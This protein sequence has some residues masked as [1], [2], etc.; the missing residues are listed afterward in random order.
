[1]CLGKR[2]TN[3]QTSNHSLETR[4]VFVRAPKLYTALFCR[5]LLVIKN[6]VCPRC[7]RSVEQLLKGNQLHAAYVRLGEVELSEP[8][9]SK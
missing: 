3:S 5:M 7:I 2:Q 1:M 4:P 6:M 8:P 9:S